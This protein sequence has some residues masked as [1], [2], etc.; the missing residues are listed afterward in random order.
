MAFFNTLIAQT[1]DSRQNLIDTPF[2]QACLRGE[3]WPESYRAFL[4]ET[5]HHARHTVPIL[6]ACRDALKDRP[7]WLVAA[8]DEYID[9]EQ[10]HGERILN[11]IT[12]SGGDAQSVRHGTPNAATEL[13]VAC[14]YDMIDRHQAIGVFGMLHV[15][16]G[17]TVALAL[18]AT[19]RI[20]QG[21]RWPDQAF[22]Y[23]RSHGT[24]DRERIAQFAMLMDEIDKEIDRRTIIDSA[25]MFYRLY[26][27]MLRS[28][29]Q[30]SLR[31]AHCDPA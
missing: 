26:G 9:D 6:R 27:D 19:D 11:D 10:G 2:V 18:A 14:A 15:L 29:P 24:F 5:Y 25:R 20:Q 13:L 4:Q 12:A 30:V 31:S 3:V 22:T 8:L 16:E 21:L 23:L 17:T 28:L 1:G 7:V